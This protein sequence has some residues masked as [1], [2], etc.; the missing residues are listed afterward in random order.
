MDDLFTIKDSRIDKEELI[1]KLQQNLNCRKSHGAYS[2][3]DELLVNSIGILSSQHYNIDVLKAEIGRLRMNTGVATNDY[4]LASHRM[5]I[6]PVLVKGRMLVNGEVKRYVDPMLLRQ[7]TFNLDLIRYQEHFI[8][9]VEQ[10]FG[11]LRSE[12]IVGINDRSDTLRSALSSDIG[13]KM[14]AVQREL[15]DSL[16]NREKL[17]TSANSSAFDQMKSEMTALVDA[18]IEALRSELNSSLSQV[19]SEL[20]A[21]NL[22]ELEKVKSDVSASIVRTS[23]HIEGRVA[24]LRTGMRTDLN[25]RVSDLRQEFLQDLCDRICTQREDLSLG[26][27]LQLSDELRNIICALGKALYDTS[28]NSSTTPP[29]AIPMT[30]TPDSGDVITN[31]YLQFSREIGVSWVRISGEAP[32]TPNL[33]ADAISIFRGGSVVLDVGCGSGFFLKMLQNAGIPAYGVDLNE[34]LVEYCKN[35]GL[36]VICSD[37]IRHLQTLEDG[38]LDGIFICQVLEHMAIE[39]IDQLISLC[40]NKL[41]LGG[42]LIASIPNI[43]NIIVSSNLYYM[44]PTHRTHLHPEVLKFILRKCSFN[45]IEDHYYQQVPDDRKL[46]TIRLPDSDKDSELASVMESVNHNVELLNNLLFSGR[47]YAAV[48]RK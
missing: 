39:D 27:D 30:K 37:A 9:Y 17:I 23:A 13:E 43:Q 18:R 48:C 45:N 19:K 31:N 20:A 15:K 22:K 40:Y 47:D 29:L 12:T 25:N 24:D 1:K 44:D 32:V 41:K 2:K 33:M 42:A 3:K 21:D 34:K 4:Q 46:K 28:Y 14:L 6:G 26:T 5:F 36:D 7:Q 35:N 10:S 38:V 16:D 11:E 8:N